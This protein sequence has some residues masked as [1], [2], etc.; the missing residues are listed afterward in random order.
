MKKR[1]V[2]GFGSG[3]VIFREGD[4]ADCMYK[5]AY[6]LVDIYINYKTAGQKLLTTVQED[7]FFG[8]MALIDD[9]ARSATAV[10]RSA[11]TKLLVYP[12]EELDVML[13]EETPVFMD[14]L[15]Q[16]TSNLIHLTDKY[17]DVCRTIAEYRRCEEEGNAIGSSLQES[18]D[19]YAGMAND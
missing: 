18:I 2:K 15:T 13:R 10:S 19:K 16:M 9:T 6:G 17:A 12:K 8:E 4:K 14:L 5:V 3:T 1:E 7:E 11:D